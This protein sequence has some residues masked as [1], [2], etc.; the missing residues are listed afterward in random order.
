MIGSFP[1]VL[2]FDRL[3]L[4]IHGSFVTNCRFSPIIAHY[5][6]RRDRNSGRLASLSLSVSVSAHMS[7]STFVSCYSG[8]QAC[9]WRDHLLNQPIGFEKG[10]FTPWT[11]KSSQGPVKYVIG[12]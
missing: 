11:M 4:K 12:C 10:L 9:R 6:F 7:H 1:A 8:N 5:Y 3:F 2:N